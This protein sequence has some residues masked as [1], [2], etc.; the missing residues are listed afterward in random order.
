MLSFLSLYSSP[1]HDI[2]IMSQNCWILKW[3]TNWWKEMAMCQMVQW[4]DSL[5]YS[6]RY[7]D[8]YHNLL[9]EWHM[10]FSSWL[11]V[12]WPW[13]IFYKG[14]RS[15]FYNRPEFLHNPCHHFKACHPVSYMSSTM[16]KCNAYNCTS[17]NYLTVFSLI[18]KCHMNCFPSS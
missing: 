8:T 15:I 16:N 10:V 1:F 11:P 14:P 4:W 3:T 7:V 5:C 18:M 17:F 9:V 13:S 6:G 12:N 2:G